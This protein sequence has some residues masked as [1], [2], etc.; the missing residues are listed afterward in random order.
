[1]AE[2]VRLT[3]DSVG[4]LEPPILYQRKS[5]ADADV[6]PE[7]VGQALCRARQRSG[8]L[9]MDVWRELKIPPHHLIAIETSCFEALPGRVYAIGFVRS[10]AAYLG[11]D[12][13]KLVA[14]LK[15]EM[16]GPDAKPPEAGRLR[17]PERKDRVEPEFVASANAMAPAIGLLSPPERR[18]P[19]GLIAGLMIAALIYSGYD[20]L[21]SAWHA[22]EPPVIP[23]PARLAAEA[24]L[25]QKQ[26]GAPPRATVPPQSAPSTEIAP[27]QPVSLPSSAAIEAASRLPPEPAPLPTTNAAP[28]EPASVVAEP[29]PT[30]RPPLPLGRR[31]GMRNRNSRIILRVHRP[32][33]VAVQGTRNRIFLDRVLDPGDTY[34]VPNMAGLKL[35]AP[36]AGAIEVILDDTTVGFAGKDGVGA[37]GLSLDP[38][39]FVARRQD[40]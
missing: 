5:S 29:A 7:S 21:G 38:K 32:I 40:G 1:M 31:Y 11:L 19:H 13:E 34:R 36:D 26:I 35:S 17:V 14:R 9:L 25:T 4:E 3:P 6:L 20:F 18:L 30:L 15:D 22:A 37:K 24:G 39:S 27:A 10:Y 33:H 28:T 16:A 8:K 12:A 23:V 2:V